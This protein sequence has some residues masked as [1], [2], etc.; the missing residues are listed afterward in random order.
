MARPRADV[1]K[2]ARDRLVAAIDG[3]GGGTSRTV[4]VIG[5]LRSDYQF[6][7]LLL[8]RFPAGEDPD[9]VLAAVAKRCAAF[10]VAVIGADGGGNG[11][12]YNR[13]LLD[14]LR[15]ESG[16]YAILYSAGDQAPRRDGV[17]MKWTVNRS[18]TIGALFSRV[19]KKNIVF[20]RLQDCGSYL[21]EFACEAA[22]YDDINRTVKYSHP[23]TQPD[24]AL[25][26]TNYALLV[27]VLRF[28]SSD[29]G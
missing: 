26:A 7:V 2:P 27:G 4:L 5:Y 19:K 20:P 18:A 15:R 17:L 21:D 28:S 23:E 12:V 8:E 24:D 22:E 29:D 3:G 10:R 16:L 11:H 9:Q 25:H 1:P 6:Q 13:L 14:R